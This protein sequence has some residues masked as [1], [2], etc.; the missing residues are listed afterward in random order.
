[1]YFKRRHKQKLLQVLEALNKMLEE[2]QQIDY[3]E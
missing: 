2:W 1:M 3:I